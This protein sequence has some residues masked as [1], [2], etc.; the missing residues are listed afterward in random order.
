MQ[1]A[2]LRGLLLLLVL[3]ALGCADSKLVA[4]V[5]GAEATAQK[6]QQRA[7]QTYLALVDFMTQ[8]ELDKRDAARAAYCKNGQVAR[9]M[10]GLARGMASTC[11]AEALNDAI[12]FI[13]NLPK[14]VSY[15]NPRTGTNSLKQTRL[16]AIRRLLPPEKLHTSTRLFVLV[17]PEDDSEAAKIHA[18]EV[19]RRFIEDI[20]RK[21][22]PPPRPLRP[23]EPPAAVRQVP[24]LEPHLLPCRL[25]GKKN[26]LYP[27]L[28]DRPIPGEPLEREPAIVIWTFL[29]DC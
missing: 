1:V 16:G 13:T 26:V 28:V 20:L 25:R 22:L 10:E 17:Q 9:F 11:S 6:A 19:A 3:P 23:H 2:H 21:E 8:Q 12:Y 24:I 7:D 29:T 14:V 4:R 5:A 18:E 27:N 15:L